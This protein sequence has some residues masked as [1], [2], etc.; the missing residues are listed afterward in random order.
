MKNFTQNFTNSKKSLEKIIAVCC[1]LL[2]SSLSYGQPGNMSIN[3]DVSGIYANTAMTLFGGA[4]QARFQESTGTSSGTRNWQFNSDS[5][6][7]TWGARSNSTLAAYN[8]TVVANTGTASANWANGCSP[9]CYNA[10]GK[11]QATQTGFYYTYNITRGSAYASQLMGV[12]ETSYN[13]VSISTVAQ[14]NSTFGSRIITITTSGTPNASENIYVR[15]STNSYAA[16]TLVQATGSG[17]TWTATIPWQSSPVSFYVYS[18]PKTLSTINTEV[19]ASGQGVHD[20]S[21]LNLNNNGGTNYSWT[22]A[23]GAII[24]TSSGGTSA[25]TPVGYASLTAA[26][27]LFSVLNTGTVH[28]GTV[29]ALILAD[30]TETGAVALNNSTAWTALTINPSGARTLSGAPAAGTPLIDLNGADNVTFNGLN[31]GGNALTLSNTTVGATFTVRFTGDA[32]G[33]TI[34]NCTVLGSSTGGVIA[35]S[36]TIFF[37]TSTTSGNDNNTISNNNIGPAGANLPS[38]AIYGNGSTTSVTRGNSGITISGNNIYD[39]YLSGAHAAIYMNDGNL[40]WT[41]SNN[42]FYQSATRSLSGVNS[43]IFINGSTTPNDGVTISGNTIGFANNTGTGTY[44][45][46]LASGATFIPINI[47]AAGPTTATSVQG[48]TIKAI[49]ISGA[50]NGTG[51]S[52]P[53]RGIYVG[54]GLTTIGDVTANTIGDMSTTGSITYTSSSTSSS[55]IYGMLNYGSSN[56]TTNN[57]NIGGFTLGNSSTGA[58]NFYGLR[59][60]TTSS[61]TWTCNNNIIGGTIVNSIS[62]TS[63]AVGTIVNGIFN[64]LASGTFSGNIIRNLT[65]AGGTGTGASSSMIGIRIDASSAN[66]TV[67]QN[68]IFGL[69]NSNSGG[70]AVIVTG[71]RFSSTSGTNLIARNLIYNLGVTT[72]V[73][74]N[75]NGIAAIGGTATY[76]N[77]MVRLG[78]NAAGTAIT[79]GNAFNGIIA[80]GGTNNFFNNSVYIGGTGVSGSTATNAFACSTTSARI[81]RNNIFFNGRSNTAGTGKHYAINE[82]S[83]TG[84]TINHNNYFA[85]GTGG[86]LGIL[87][88]ERATLSAWQTA[89]TQDANSQNGDP[90]FIAPTSAIP[91]LHISPTNPT[92]IEATGILVATVT[93]DYDGE[94]RSGLTPTDIGAD[95]GNFVSAVAACVTPTTQPTALTFSAVTATTLSGSFTAASPIPSGYLVI[96]STSST[97]SGNPVDGISY[98]SGNSLGGGTVIIPTGTTFTDSALTAGTTYFYFVLS[99]N[100][101]SCS[102]GPKYLTTT[103]LTNNQT[104]VCAAATALADGTLTPTSATLTWTG[105]GN[106]IVEYGAVGFTP[107][108]GATAGA[109]GTIA[110]STGTTPYVLSGL[111]SN[112]TY[113]VYVRQVCAVGGF[114]SANSTKDTFT[115]LQIPA[116]LPYTQN[117]TTANDFVFVNGA[118]TN[119]W[120]YGAATGNPANSLYISNNSGAAN[121]YSNTI[122]T[123]AHAF[124]PIAIP[125]GTTLASFSFDWKAVGESCCDYLRVW[126]VPENFTPTAGTQITAGSGR[127]QVGGNFNNQT[128]WQTYSS[129]VLNLT[130]FANTTMRLVFEWRNDGSSGSTPAAID[131]ISLSIPSCGVPAI[132]AT[133]NIAETTA[134]INWTAPA[135]APSNGYNYEVRTSGAAGSGAT[136][137]TSSGAVAA[138]IVTQNITSLT[139]ATTYSVYIQSNCGGSEL[140]SWSIVGTFTTAC[141]V[142][143]SP[144]TISVTAPLATGVTLNYGAATPAPTNYILFSS[145]GTVAT[146]I[147]I[148]VAGTNYV[149][150]TAYTFGGSS[151][152]C[153]TNT[154]AS[155]QVLTGGI[156]NT[157]YNYFLYSRSTTNNCFGNP[158]YSNGVSVSTITCPAAPTLPVVSLVTVSS[159]TVSWTASIIGG[160]AGSINYTLEVYTDAGYTTPISGSPFITG[161]SV[162]QALTGLSAS[163]IYYYRVK[164]NNGSCDSTYLTGT[165]TTTCAALT[166]FPSVEPFASYLPSVCWKEGDLGDLTTGP[167]TIGSLTVSDW[168][169]DGFLNSGTTGAAKMNIDAATGSEWII[170]PFYTIPATGYRVKYSV[171]ATQWDVTTALTTAW[172]ADDFVELLVSTS[173]TN[174]TVLKTY[175]SANVPSHLGQIDDIDLTAYNGQTVQFAFRAFEGASNGSADIDFFIDNFTIEEAPACLSTTMNA[176]TAITST[177][178]TINWT[179][180]GSA[181]SN[182]YN[183]EVRTSGAAG[184]GAT[185][186]TTSGSV[187][188]GVLSANITGLTATTTYSVYVQSN[189]GGNGT[190][191]WSTAVTFTTSCNIVTSFPYVMPFDGSA[192]CWT[193]SEGTAPWVLAA[194]STDI[195]SPQSGSGFAFKP[196]TTSTQYLYSAPMNLSSFGSD[197]ARL[198]FWIYRHSA[199]VIADQISFKINTTN[200]NAGATN[201]QT[202]N[203][204]STQSPVEATSGWYNYRVDIPTSWNSAGIVYIVVEGITTAGLSSYDIGLDNFV[205]EL[206]PPSIT[207]TP[208]SSLTICSGNSISL[209]ASSTAD[210][211]YTWTPSTGLSSTSG[212][213]V[214]ANPTTTTTYTV[215]GVAGAMTSTQ[216]VTVTVNP[217]PASVTISPN[218]TS[219]QNNVTTLTASSA[220]IGTYT[221]GT[222]TSTSIAANTPYRQSVG[223]QARMQYLITKNELN[224]AG[225]NGPANITSIAFNVTSAGAGTIPTYTISMGNS[226]ATV[227]TTTFQTPILTTVY[228]VNNYVVSSGVNT[229]AFTTPFAWNGTSNVIVNICMAGVSGGTTSVV[230]VSTPAVVSTTSLNGANACSTAT[231]NNTASNRPIM[232]FGFA[233]QITWSPTSDLFTDLGATIAYSGGAAGTVYAKPSTTTTYTATASVGSCIRTAESTV[234]VNPSSVAG[235][236]TGA[237]SVCT[238][239]NSTTLTLSGNTGTIQWQSSSDNIAFNNIVDQTATTYI[240]TNLTATTYYRAVVTSGVCSS[241]TTA[242]EVITVNP[243]PS[244]ANAGLDQQVCSANTVILAANTATFGSGAWSIVSGSGGTVTTPSSPTSTFTGTPGTTYTLRWTIS[245]GVCNTSTDDVVITILSP[246]DFINLQFPGDAAICQGNF[247]TAF[248]QVFESGITPGAGQGANIAVEFGYSGTNTNPSTWTNW[249]TASYNSTVTGSNDEYQYVFTPSSAG[250]YYYTFRYKQG[251]CDTWQYGGFSGSGGGAWGGSN[252]SGVLTVNSNAAHTIGLTSGSST[253]SLCQNTVLGTDIIYAIGGGATGA[254]VTGLPSGM[255]GSFSSGNFTISGTPAT[256]GA[257]NYTV[258]TT[259]NGC[260]NAVTASGTITVSST[261]DFVNMQFPA[262]GTICQTSTFTAYG[263]VYELGVTPGAGQGAGITVEFGYNSTNT[264]PSTWSNWFTASH[265]PTFTGNNDEYLYTLSPPSSGTFYYAF[266]YKQGTCDWQYGGYTSGGGG[267]WGGSNVSGVLTVNPTLTSSV[268]AAASPSGPICVGTSVTFTATPTNGGTSP[269]YQWLVNGSAVSGQ[270]ASTFTSTTIANND[271]VTVQMTS[272]AT[273][274]LTGSPVT[275]TGITMTVNP[276]VAASVSAAASPSGPICVGT[277]VTFT[278]TPT[279][280]GTTPAYQWSVNGAPVSGQTASTF[281]STT[282]ANSDTVTVEMTSNATPCLTGSPATSN[283]IAITVSNNVSWVGTTG[284]WS[285]TANW[286]CGSVPLDS[287][288][289]TISSGTPTLDVNFTVGNSGSLALEGTASLIIAPTASL[290]VAGSA[291]FNARPVLFE[292]DATGTGEFGSLTGTLIGATNVTTERYFPAKRAFRFTSS[293][294][295]TNT[296][297]RANWQEGVNNSNTTFV[298]NQNP[299]PGYGTHITGAGGSANGFD[300]TISNASSLFTFNNSTS[301]W[302]AVANTNVN[303]LDAGVPYRINVRGDRSIDMSVTNPDATPTTLR[304]TGTLYTGTYTPSTISSVAAAYNFIGNPYQAPVNM[305]TVLDNA[306]NLNNQFYYVWDPRMGTRGAYISV[307]L[308]LNTPNN[309]TS[310]STKF[311]QPGQACFVRTAANGGA[312]INFQE[313]YKDLTASNSL[314]YRNSNQNSSTTSNIK[315]R[316]Y[317]SNSLALNQT[318]L[319]GSII[320]FDD[321]NNNGVD[322]NDAAKFANPDEMFSTFNSGTLVS[323]EKRMQP[324]SSDII[325]IRISQYRGTN[326]TIVAEG[327][328][329]NGV[330]AYLHDQFLQ[331]YTEVPQNGTVDYVFSISSTVTQSSASDRFRIVYNNP[332][333]S[334]ANNEWANFTMYPN[335][336]KQGNFTILLP[337]T[338]SNGTVTL[339]NALGEKIF[340]QEFVSERQFN[341]KPNQPLASGIYFVELQYDSLKS[342][343]KLIIE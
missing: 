146:A 135:S 193:T 261:L 163:T 55:E 252:V 232:T 329:L 116:A 211:A 241:A 125:S 278:A 182:G 174:W 215:T 68:T 330:P 15:Y 29:T 304:A 33:N 206:K 308:N 285:D 14:A 264:N 10:F 276:I 342:V 85:N 45:L 99:L 12:L 32:I 170:S 77:N 115:T 179:A 242:S 332:L 139:A 275:S 268:S 118:Q 39:Y 165:L 270:T 34:T 338:I 331:T 36:G 225:I 282:L 217:V 294:V 207:I 9:N 2:V 300:T 228:T 247:L 192:N 17:N 249:F 111:S 295:T 72:S 289:I 224:A 61:V 341:V 107:G 49:A 238:G 335:P 322:Q 201:L 188:A 309:I 190:S 151:Y 78:Y 138:G 65:V 60:W 128:T 75:V 240:A 133:N 199:T 269:A 20:V 204:L 5:Y 263:Q 203:I 105:V 178:A 191:S 327:E 149:N 245:S 26:G 42:K 83:T 142:P 67:R 239:T 91:D 317:N 40:G 129:A 321:S 277:S 93:D 313:S 173:N 4:Y 127:I 66:H 172:E 326:Y 323:I 236:I 316:L 226:N 51:T 254:G 24:V 114:Y 112:T 86:V 233:G 7:N 181:P 16:S 126:L 302:A 94:T 106:Y 56:W 273:P 48:N 162:S 70:S 186:L 87:S 336:S 303:K 145:T 150:N 325:P 120:V 137:L 175:N 298:N 132:A 98:T 196:F 205:V 220:T 53:F 319:D 244:V 102:G 229:H 314:V 108:T 253:P 312:S 122:N 213:T 156:S 35:N 281:T 250:T 221:V 340:T 147:P 41:I 271:V 52:A 333:L 248:G 148:L 258:T 21:M 22:P 59:C 154:S 189:C 260:T 292:S 293:A 307:D 257:F 101:G 301:V 117:F 152:N 104:T 180:S 160:G 284:L 234:S 272:N 46:S 47:N 18:S 25:N 246:L 195:S 343:K 54:A 110:T 1:L 31:T 185:G 328:N 159:A 230:S 315:M 197:Q 274:C 161:S 291:N 200:S 176:S 280:G 171:G 219:C 73:A 11:L 88:T 339:F 74:S 299:N 202:Y 30:V 290:T 143:N 95:A 288:I 43:V 218:V 82:S 124:R 155:P 157:Q 6:S 158:Y 286:S 97:L 283:S 311:L 320:F 123:V 227:M 297:I 27:G 166:S 103:P 231:G 100:T 141:T 296:T 177:T 262:S 184:S 64:D 79:G 167:T 287:S 214:S 183:Y 57:N 109:G 237:G 210:Y 3:Q 267:T 243:T 76:Q 251:T 222:A 279:N 318:A 90:Q 81:I 235:T 198:N 62:N 19:S 194:N 38:K 8:T 58:T 305:K 216:T 265:N 130:T 334:A 187:A 169:V 223:T 28:T 63:T 337:Q 13:P 209:T 84:L 212:A 121:A 144:G 256:G 255:S 164:A 50:G 140:S 266:R 119:I 80:T 92:P 44:T 23:T 89:T 69:A 136:G 131:N 153:I 37:S 310:A 168:V 96:R 208:S 113:D 71:I 259:G 324:I 134:T 306:T